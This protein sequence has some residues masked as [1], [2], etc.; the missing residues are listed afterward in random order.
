MEK[1]NDQI[2]KMTT[3]FFEHFSQ[4]NNEEMNYKPEPE[5]W[6]ISQNIAHLLEVNNSYFPVFKNLESGNNRLPF[7]ARFGFMASFFGNLIKKSVEPSRKKKIKTF[8]VW[9]PSESNFSSE[10]LSHFK[11][12][13]EELKSYIANF[14]EH[15]EKKKVISSPANKNIVYRLET[16]LDIIIIHQ[17]RHFYQA[18]E[19]KEQLLK[20]PFRNGKD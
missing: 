19:I 9:Q 4:L 16:A 8:P 17:E 7:I 12:S 3:N 14:P 1:W 6:S 20:N 5:T 13:Q 11:S 10:I 15:I 2:D 18:L